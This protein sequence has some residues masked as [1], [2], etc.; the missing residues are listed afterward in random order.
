[1]DSLK[2]AQNIDLFIAMWSISESPLKL[3]ENLFE[4]IFNT[5]KI[6]YVLIGFQKKF[7]DIDNCAYFKTF[8]NKYNNYSWKIKGIPHLK[9]NHYLL[10]KNNKYDNH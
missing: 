3:R 6:K 4:K 9:D 2:R 10:G 1:M 8:I 7:G 5:A